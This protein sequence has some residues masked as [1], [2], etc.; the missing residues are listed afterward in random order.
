VLI[1]HGSEQRALLIAEAREQQI[2]KTKQNGVE[3][4]LSNSQGTATG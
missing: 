3:M 4:R 1:L 2:E